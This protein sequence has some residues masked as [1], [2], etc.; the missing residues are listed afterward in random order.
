[1]SDE[2]LEK[3]IMKEDFA[4]KR[5][6]ARPHKRWLYLI[7]ED[8]GLPVATA[9]TYAKDKDRWRKNINM[10]KALIRGVQLS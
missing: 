9:E 5:T 3:R 4:K 8:T 10:G 2:S 1:M 7:K 6:S